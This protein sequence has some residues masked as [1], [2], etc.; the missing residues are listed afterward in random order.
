MHDQIQRLARRYNSDGAQA[1][2]DGRHG[3]PGAKDRV[4]LSVDQQEELREALKKPPYRAV[5]HG[6]SADQHERE[7][8]QAPVTMIARPEPTQSQVHRPEPD[9]H[10]AEV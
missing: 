8:D 10:A 5:S 6:E 7:P 9:R 3:N 2:G 1:L 4:L